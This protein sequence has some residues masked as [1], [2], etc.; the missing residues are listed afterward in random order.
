[1]D[2]SELVNVLTAVLAVSM[3][4]LVIRIFRGDISDNKGGLVFAIVIL[5]IVIY[6][7]RSDTGLAVIEQ[8]LGI[9][10][11]GPPD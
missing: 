11:P 9:T 3:V 2:P 10:S 1:M 7:I 8:V 6:F 5:G 4:I